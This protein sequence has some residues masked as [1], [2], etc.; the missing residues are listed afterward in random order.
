MATVMVAIPCLPLVKLYLQPLLYYPTRFYP[1]RTADQVAE[2]GG[3]AL[4]SGSPGGRQGLEGGPVGCCAVLSSDLACP[5]PRAS[6]L[7]ARAGTSCSSKVFPLWAALNC[8]RY[9]GLIL[10]FSSRAP[11]TPGVTWE[12]GRRGDGQEVST[13]EPASA[14]VLTGPAFL[15]ESLMKWP[16]Q[17][18]F[19]SRGT[20][21]TTVVEIPGLGMPGPQI[22]PQQACLQRTRP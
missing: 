3:G 10:W 19:T 21:V 2:A 1:A 18:D 20:P 12:S 14:L 8:H 6:H 16:S 9:F 13:R 22:G 15:G 11:G 7:E 5:S 17:R 4:L